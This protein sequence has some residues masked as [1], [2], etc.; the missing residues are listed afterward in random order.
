MLYT[1]VLNN[2]NVFLM[3]LEVG[4]SE[5]GVQTYL[6]SGE[7]PLVGL[8]MA[9]FSLYPCTLEGR[10]S[11]ISSSSSKATNSIMTAPPS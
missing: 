6:G 2:R 1:G 10:I 4:R 3:D 7:S 8:E 11:D 5:I 9:I